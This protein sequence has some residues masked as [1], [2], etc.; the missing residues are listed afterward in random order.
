MSLTE[1]DLVSYSRMVSR[2]PPMD[3]LRRA[4]DALVAEV[5]ALRA[6][7]PEAGRFP[8][9]A[10]YDP[11]CSHPGCGLRLSEHVAPHAKPEAGARVRTDTEKSRAVA[12]ET[13][14]PAFAAPSQ[15]AGPSQ[16]ERGGVVDMRDVAL[17]LESYEWGDRDGF[18][19]GWREGVEAAAKVCDDEAVKADGFKWRIVPTYLRNTAAVIRSLR[20]PSG[21]AEPVGTDRINCEGCPDCRGE[22]GATRRPCRCEG[23][24]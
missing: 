11:W 13:S 7:S 1:F 21:D 20:S 15:P 16:E 2:S 9:G 3:P 23:K 22:D 14:A 24:R 5:R 6:S 19:R 8:S 18:A 4:V 17:K 10:P 12:P